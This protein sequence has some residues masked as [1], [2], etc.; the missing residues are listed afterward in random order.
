MVASN[1]RP[2][3][4]NTLKGFFTLRLASGLVINGCSLHEKNVQHW[5]GLPG[6]PQ[7]DASG[8]HRTDL[9]GKKLYSPAVEITGKTARERFRAEALGA[10]D[11]MLAEVAP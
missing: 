4:K 6:A 3:E 11:R 8:Q 9:A 5:V 2:V 1:W 10:V 7:L